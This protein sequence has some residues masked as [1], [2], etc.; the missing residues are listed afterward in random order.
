M[1]AVTAVDKAVTGA[2]LA[3]VHPNLSCRY[4][5]E[6]HTGYVNGLGQYTGV[7]GEVYRGEWLYGKRHGCGGSRCA[8]LPA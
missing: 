1:D 8:A 7:N 4:E 6:F 5:G 2:L 3:T